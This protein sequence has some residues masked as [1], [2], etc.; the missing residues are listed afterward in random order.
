MI[1]LFESIGRQ[2]RSDGGAAADAGPIRRRRPVQRPESAQRSERDRAVR[3]DAVLASV[4]C[5]AVV[6]RLSA[7]TG[8]SVVDQ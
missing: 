3:S 4:Y 6:R 7:P 8:P 5:R 1:E 2:G